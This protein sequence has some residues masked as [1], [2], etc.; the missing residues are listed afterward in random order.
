MIDDL[1]RKISKKAQKAFYDHIK[2]K[3]EADVDRPKVPGSLSWLDLA[4]LFLVWLL[5]GA[6]VRDIEVC[7]IKYILLLTEKI[8]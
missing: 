1:N 8:G 3:L 2:N 4:R 6:S 7:K 5:T